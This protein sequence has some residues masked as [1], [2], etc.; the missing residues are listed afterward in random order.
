MRRIIRA[1]GIERCLP[2]ALAAFEEY[3]H[4]AESA[5]RAR[6]ATDRS[7]CPCG[8]P[9]CA[10]QVGLQAVGHQR[11]VAVGAAERFRDDGVDYAQLGRSLAVIFSASAARSLKVWLFHRM[12]AQ[13][14]GL[15]TE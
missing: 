11:M 9:Q 8:S 13:P 15:M 4:A 12:P 6:R 2:I 5:V 1:S 14:S 3:A 10:P 7:A